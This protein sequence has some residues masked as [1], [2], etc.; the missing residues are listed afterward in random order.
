MN[1]EFYDSET[2]VKHAQKIGTQTINPE[3]NKQMWQYSK[4]ESRR[5]SRD[6]N[7]KHQKHTYEKSW[8]TW[9]RQTGTYL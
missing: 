7:Q 8:N 9:Q 6:Q 3:R 1:S 2:V 5:Q 4:T